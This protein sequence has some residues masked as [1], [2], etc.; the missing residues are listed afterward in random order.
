MDPGHRTAMDEFSMAMVDEV[1]LDHWP[2]FASFSIKRWTFIWKVG[3]VLWTCVKPAA[4]MALGFGNS[5]FIPLKI[6][7]GGL[8]HVWI[9]TE[10]LH[11]HGGR[12]FVKIA[13]FLGWLPSKQQI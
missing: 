6:I 4:L 11:R 5:Y 9:L 8:F 13:T 7:G 2:L 1:V 3:L 12:P 10:I